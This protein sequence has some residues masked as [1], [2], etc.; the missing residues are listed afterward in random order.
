LQSPADP[1]PGQEFSEIALRAHADDRL[2]A[3]GDTGP[4]I[5]S[6]P[7]E[8]GDMLV[9]TCPVPCTDIAD[10]SLAVDGHQVVVT[11]PGGFRHELA[12]PAEAD[13]SGLGV[14]LYRGILELRTPH[15]DASRVTSIAA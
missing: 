10:I 1:I 12:L 11:A 3:A 7:H 5:A 2:A 14:E 13:M 6:K 9:I 4:M 8:T 15:A